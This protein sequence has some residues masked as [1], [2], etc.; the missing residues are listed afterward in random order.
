MDLSRL[1]DPATYDEAVRLLAAL[2][3]DL[4]DDVRTLDA[5]GLAAPSL[6][7]G[8]TRAHVLAHVAR[9]ADAL[10]NLLTWARTGQ[11]RPMYADREQRDAEIEAGT[12][13][14]PA[15]LEADVESSA[16]RFLAAAAELP[17][18]RRDVEVRPGPAAQGHPIPA[19]DVLWNRI[20]EVA[21]HHVDLGTGRRFADLPGPV[22]ARGLAEA[23]QRTGVDPGAVGV[24]GDPAALLGWLTGREDGATLTSP[25]PLPAVP[26]WG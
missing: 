5:A 26:S 15:D 19:A 10:V 11:A 13:L 9:N 12:R 18:D 14:A 20:R 1:D 16:E 23:V 24:H 17:V 2:T 6:L 8:W 22:V 25:G 21:Y 4:L 7:P 3:D